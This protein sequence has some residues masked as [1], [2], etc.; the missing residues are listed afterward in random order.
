M[1]AA[2]PA[3]PGQRAPIP[4][5]A[6]THARRAGTAARLAPAAHM[7]GRQ[8][9]IRKRRALDEE[10]EEEQQQQQAAGGEG[11]QE[12][13][14]GGL[15]VED[16]KLL[17]KQRQ[18][19]TVRG[20]GGRC[21]ACAP[22]GR[23]RRAAPWHTSRRAVWR[24]WHCRARPHSTTDPA[25]PAAL[26]RPGAPGPANQGIDASSL[27]VADTAPRLADVAAGAAGPDVLVGAFKKEK[28]QAAA[29]EDPH[30]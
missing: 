20:R 15:S 3:E 29:A 24:A 10:E 13:G 30:M 21:C 17:Q 18:R 1:P 11:E 7:S 12:Q 26:T 23:R 22:P 9:N 25:R 14:G 28:R 27:A 6:L 8:R 16:T 19:R 2:H 4:T 5:L